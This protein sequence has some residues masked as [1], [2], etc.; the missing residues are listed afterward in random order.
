[1]K[2]QSYESGKDLSLEEVVK[3]QQLMAKVE[4]SWGDECPW[5]HCS[6]PDEQ[7]IQ[8]DDI[9]LK[10]ALAAVGLPFLAGSIIVSEEDIKSYLPN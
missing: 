6:G 10:E 9:E 8:E 5:V 2:R 7:F 3:G 1:M 4:D